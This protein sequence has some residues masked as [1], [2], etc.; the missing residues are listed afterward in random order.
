MASTAGT[1][2]WVSTAPDGINTADVALPFHPRCLPRWIKNQDATPSDHE[3]MTNIPL[4]DL[5]LCH[6]CSWSCITTFTVLL[7]SFWAKLFST[8]HCGMLQD[9]YQEEY[10]APFPLSLPRS[11]EKKKRKRDYTRELQMLRRLSVG[12]GRA[13]ATFSRCSTC[14]SWCTDDRCECL[15]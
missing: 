1:C 10:S 13:D 9:E 7:A 5:N 2:H 8:F 4:C 12:K 14:S 6:A 15:W 3:S 11:W